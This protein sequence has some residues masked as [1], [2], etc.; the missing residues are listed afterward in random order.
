MEIRMQRLCWRITKILPATTL[1]ILGGCGVTDRQLGD[2]A[3]SS[4]VRV[5]VQAV[6]SVLE[7]AI[8]QGAQGGV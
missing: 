2:F 5:L 3:A 1:G 7:S 6:A 4:A 8:L